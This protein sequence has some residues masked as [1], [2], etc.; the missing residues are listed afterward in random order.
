MVAAI[1]IPTT[2][3]VSFLVHEKIPH[4]ERISCFTL[5][6]K[7]IA[8][9]VCIHSDDSDSDASEGDSDASEMADVKP[10]ISALKRSHST[11]QKEKMDKKIVDLV[12]DDEE[13]EIL[14]QRI[15]LKVAM[16]KSKEIFKVSDEAFEEANQRITDALA[17]AVHMEVW[18]L[19]TK[20]PNLHKR[21]E[22][23]HVSF[24][25]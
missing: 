19:A 15:N 13:L 21:R 10:D 2:A 20:G 11:Q 8:T 12:S 22:L 18:N 5:P 25:V 1:L 7:P 23:L 14:Q 3:K 17:H 9:L 16:K 4:H 6:L 24:H